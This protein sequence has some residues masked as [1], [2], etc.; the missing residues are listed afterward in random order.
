MLIDNDH[1]SWLGFVYLGQGIFFVNICSSQNGRYRTK[2]N[3]EFGSIK[4][5]K[6][7]LTYVALNQWNESIDL[8]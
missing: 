5:N 3:R 6:S 4:Y 7:N 8:S 1:G 2:N